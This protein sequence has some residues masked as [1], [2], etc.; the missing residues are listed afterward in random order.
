MSDWPICRTKDCG[1]EVNP[2]RWSLGYR[3]CLRCGS[4]RKE[5]I[6]GQAYN[7]GGLQLITETDVKDM[8]RKDGVGEWTKTTL[9][10]D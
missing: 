3:T 5:F 2:A 8:G 10:R 4:P 7:K 6:V 1:E 9:C